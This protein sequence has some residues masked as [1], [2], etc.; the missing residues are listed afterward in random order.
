MGSISGFFK[1]KDGCS[2][3]SCPQNV[4]IVVLV[5]YESN[6]LNVLFL[7]RTNLYCITRIRNQRMKKYLYCILTGFVL[8][9]CFA[10]VGDDTACITGVMVELNTPDSEVL[11]EAVIWVFAQNDTLVKEYTFKN[12]PSI[13]Q[14]QILL[15]PGR[16][17]VVAQTNMGNV[18]THNAALNK[19]VLTDLVVVKNGE[20]DLLEHVHYGVV[21]CVV[22]PNRIELVSMSLSRAMAEI[23]LSIKNIPNDVR[24]V[25][26]VVKNA[27][28]GYYPAIRKLHPVATPVSL[29]ELYPIN[30]A[31]IFDKVKLLPVTMSE[32]TKDNLTETYVE[33][34]MAY[35]NGGVL[36][37]DVKGPALVNGGVYT[38]EIEYNVFRP[39]IV[40]E[41]NSI[42]G[43]K[44]LP[45]ISGE[46][47]S[48]FDNST[49]TEC[50]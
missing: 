5:F 3:N 35:D 13:T 28:T 37:F 44:E 25:A 33:F 41:L 38:P 24:S 22:E 16:Y 10:C 32:I 19:T 23:T 7:A 9:G 4:P 46:I 30:N 15:E 18:F 6:G 14:H 45:E 43:W 8:W 31:V 17:T 34:T 27:A 21:E 50:L 12:M 2:T 48:P 36:T 40:I 29:G 26:M 39:G 47:L 1:I 11:N 20:N 49:K 42:N